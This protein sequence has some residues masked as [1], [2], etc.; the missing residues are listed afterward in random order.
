M[1]KHAKVKAS[2]KPSKKASKKSLK[3][4][5]ELPGIVSGMMKL[6]ERLEVLERKTDS[7]LGRVSN[8]PAEIRQASQNLRLSIQAD[9]GRVT[10]PPQNMNPIQR[11]RYHA[12]CASCC[13]ECE[14]PFKP[15]GERPVYCKA[16]FAKRKSG[17]NPPVLNLQEKKLAIHQQ[18]S[19]SL[20]PKKDKK[21]RPVAKGKAK[22]SKKKKRK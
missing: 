8:L 17:N 1:K 10:V 21:S 18:A 5:D 9:Q 22:A 14:V 16:C 2:S 11:I 3:T 7:I 13:A 12:V 6:V 19:Q 15:T 4:T 20:P